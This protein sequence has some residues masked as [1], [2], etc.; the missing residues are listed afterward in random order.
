MD[1][2]VLRAEL[3][4]LLRGGQAHVAL[5]AALERIKPENRTKIG[6]PG[7]RSIWEELE[8]MRLAQLDIF[9]YTVD[10]SWK[11]PKWPEGYWPELTGELRTESWHES[12]TGFERDLQALIDLVENKNFDLTG[13]IPHGES[14][15]YLRE[16]LLVADHNAYHLGQ[17]VAMRKALGDWP[18]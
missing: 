15:T 11:S 9:R 18:N 14:H 13:E 4:K 7:E 16:V 5:P 12:I 2:S 6:I 8:H 3:V 17:I 1:D 10:P